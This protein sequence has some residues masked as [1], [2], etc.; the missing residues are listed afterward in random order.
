MVLSKNVLSKEGEVKSVLAVI[1]ACS[2]TFCACSA[3]TIGR[4]TTSGAMPYKIDAEGQGNTWVN[5][6]VYDS[7]GNLIG[8][9]TVFDDDITIN[10]L[11]GDVFFLLTTGWAETRLFQSGFFPI[12]EDEKGSRVV[13]TGPL[14]SSGLSCGRIPDVLPDPI[15]DQY[16]NY[17]ITPIDINATYDDTWYQGDRAYVLSIP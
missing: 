10:A 16:T 15:K 8:E 1:L 12:D 17:T 14:P 9:L 6:S 4:D 13:C 2:L 5:L 7:E 11:P 3:S